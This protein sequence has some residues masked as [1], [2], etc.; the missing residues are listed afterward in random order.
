M[1][2]VLAALIIGAALMMRVETSFRIFGYPGLPTIFFLIAALA[3][4][5]LVLSIVITDEK[6]K[7]NTNEE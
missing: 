1:T 6:P 3:G 7:K 2:L 5:V 4:V